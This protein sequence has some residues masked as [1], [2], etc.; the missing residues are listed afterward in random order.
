M[1]DEIEDQDSA[2]LPKKKGFMGLTL[3]MTAGRWLMVGVGGVSLLT[4]FGAIWL[5]TRGAHVD[6]GAD[7]NMQANNGIH[8][9]PG[10]SSPAYAAEVAAYNKKKA[11]YALSH[12]QS[13]VG[14][15]VTGTTTMNM[16]PQQAPIQQPS[17]QVQ[18]APIQETQQASQQQPQSPAADGAIAK[19][20]GAIATAMKNQRGVNPGY[21]IPQ[22]QRA[23][24]S[25]SAVSAAGLTP[26]AETSSSTPPAIP[27]GSILYGVFENALKSTMPGPVIGELV[28]GKYN[29]DRVIGSFTRTKG[30][31]HLEIRL[32]TLVLPSGKTVAIDAYAISPNTTLP[33]M[34][35]N[36]NYHILSRTANFLGA[37]FLA[38]VEGYGAA[39]AQEGSTTTSALGIGTTQTYPMLTPS[40]TM[41]IAAGQ[42]AQQLQPVQEAMA[43]NVMEPNTITVAQGTPFGLLVVSSGKT[44]ARTTVSTPVISSPVQPATTGNPAVAPTGQNGYPVQRNNLSFP[45]LTLNTG[46]TSILGRP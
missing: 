44:A 38:G 30:S 16:P 3:N 36:V 26:V 6:A 27:P 8:N 31:D 11:A 18:Q 1:S 35:T 40:Q 13:F 25:M 17:A 12:D 45:G 29:G 42:A 4:A 2:L 20:I 15:P 37:A 7:V 21:Y 5:E 43:N 10:K 34:A 14:I 32:H 22:F 9:A 41:D 19:E 24:P 23:E 46:A 28:Q 33:G 39:V